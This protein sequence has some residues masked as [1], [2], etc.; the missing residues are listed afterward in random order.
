MATT[1]QK[2][3]SKIVLHNKLLEQAELEEMLEQFEDPEI[4]AKYL[5]K[6]G[7]LSDKKADQLLALYH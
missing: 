4:I 3:F 7:K 6:R 2:I 5:V 1:Q